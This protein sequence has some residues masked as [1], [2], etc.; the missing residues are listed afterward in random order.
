M[1]KIDTLHKQIEQAEKQID[2]KER[3]IINLELIVHQLHDQL[4]AE[5]ERI[6]HE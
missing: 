2:R 3:E 5:N 4:K 1:K 6:R